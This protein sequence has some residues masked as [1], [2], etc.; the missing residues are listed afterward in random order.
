MPSNPT[1]I[2]FGAGGQLG[3]ALSQVAVPS[4][5][6][7]RELTRADVDV[8]DRRAVAD[9]LTGINSGVVVNAAAYNAVDK[10]ETEPEQAMAIN[11][12][13]AA[14]VASEASRRGLLTVHV[15]TDAVFG[16]GKRSPY[17]EDD[18]VSP[19]SAYAAS[20]AA[21]EVEVMGLPGASVLRTAWLFSARGKSFV[22]TIL[23]LALARD[24]LKVID[25]QL[26]SPTAADQLARTLV[27]V[28]ANL[29]DG[30]EGGLFHA[31][32][33]VPS[34]WFGLAS[35]ALAE[36]ASQGAKVARVLPIPASEYPL[37]AR[38]SPYAVMDSGRLCRVHGVDPMDWRQAMPSVIRQLL[39]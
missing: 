39:S 11:R 28:S 2:V 16:D 12:D 17:V 36:A 9:A 37:P 15:S 31:A 35:A 32:G 10:A 14:I 21:G 1:L 23:G 20:K 30:V 7:R 34:T 18:P 8:T 38:R 26:G 25:D 29:L 3:Q 24:E 4:G 19:L 33:S 5:W 13:G 22:R 27:R 6:A